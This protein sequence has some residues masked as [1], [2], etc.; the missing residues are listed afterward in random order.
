MIRTLAY[1]W[2]HYTHQYAYIYAKCSY[3]AYDDYI[4]RTHLSE[5]Q[6][7]LLNKYRESWKEFSEETNAD[8]SCHKG[9]KGILFVCLWKD[10]AQYSPPIIGGHFWSTRYNFSLGSWRLKDSFLSFP[11][12]CWIVLLIYLYSFT[13]TH[14][15]I[16][17]RY[18]WDSFSTNSWRPDSCPQ[19]PPIT[20]ITNTITTHRDLDSWHICTP[21]PHGSRPLPHGSRL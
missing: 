11:P 9:Q 4:K 18:K 3:Y 7:D 21:F 13:H 10:Y 8:D 20:H 6:A 14:L 5:K 15:F 16:R 12:M 2:I 19:N 17:H 1:T